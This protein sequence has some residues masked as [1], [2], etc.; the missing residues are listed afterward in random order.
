MAFYRNRTDL[1]VT[2]MTSTRRRFLGAAAGMLGLTAADS[3]R[4]ALPIC[5]VAAPPTEFPYCGEAAPERRAE[6]DAGIREFSN[7]RRVVLPRLRTLGQPLTV[8]G[9]SS[10]A[11]M[12]M[13][14]H[15]AYSTHIRGAGLFTGPPYG[16]AVTGEGSND[17]LDRLCRALSICMQSS[18]G[19]PEAA[20][21]SGLIDRLAQAGKID[22]TRALEQGRVWI[23]EGKADS[24]LSPHS[25]RVAAEVYRHYIGDS[26]AV[27]YEERDGLE[28]AW[29]TGDPAVGSSCT[30]KGPP[31]INACGY[32]GTDLMLE[33]L[34]QRAPSNR[35]GAR[36]AKFS[37]RRFLWGFGG[38]LA[39]EGL[40]ALPPTID[41]N[42]RLHVAFH[43]CEQ[44]TECLGTTF[45][46]ETGLVAA[47]AKF[48]LVVLMPQ[49]RAT[50][51]S[52][53]KGCW[54]W[55]GYNEPSRGS[56]FDPGGRP[57]DFVF[58]TQCGAQI[59]P[60]MTMAL[61]IAGGTLARQC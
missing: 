39:D 8:S 48:N 24:V 60:V 59:N 25:A 46:R 4:A 29:P 36:L 33:F 21:L 43:G 13:Q 17:M 9:I 7:L 6:I 12:A 26:L 57:D 37:Q 35:S 51:A 42:T 53:P 31:Y 20:E 61:A 3:L 49:V 44:S 19:A 18:P 22:P 28:H 45:A 58:M 47:S 54:D 34:L 16:C 55:W 50:L 10:G 40:V 52:N 2:P 56:L 11:A 30:L 41:A 27:R 32:A 38:N 5:P 23:L 15:I 14:T 1:N